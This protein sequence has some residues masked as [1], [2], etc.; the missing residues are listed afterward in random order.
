[1]LAL[2]KPDFG[3][4]HCATGFYS[5]ELR[6]SERREPVRETNDNFSPMRT[7]GSYG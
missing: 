7:A 6:C 4:A 5:I 1:M 2:A 3:K